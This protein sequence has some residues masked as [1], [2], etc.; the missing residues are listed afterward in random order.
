MT[1]NPTKSTYQL[2][3]EAD[4]I[5]EGRLVT[6]A[7]DSVNWRLRDMRRHPRDPNWETGTYSRCHLDLRINPNLKPN[8]VI[9]DL[10]FTKEWQSYVIRSV[11]VIKDII[12]GALLFTDFV[13]ADRDPYAIKLTNSRTRYGNKKMVQETLEILDKLASL[14]YNKY[15]KGKRPESITLSDWKRMK[16]EAHTNHFNK[17]TCN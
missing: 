12:N 3:P 4:E 5:V 1:S 2:F 14:G 10:V 15:E 11:F 6:H 13:F 9:F 17:H 16:R 7:H 8:T